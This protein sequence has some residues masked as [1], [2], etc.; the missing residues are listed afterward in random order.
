MGAMKR[1]GHG[2]LACLFCLKVMAA[3][4]PFFKLGFLWLLPYCAT[5]IAALLIPGQSRVRADAVGL[6]WPSFPG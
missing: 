4:S 2:Q 5:F 1:P 3:K 6:P